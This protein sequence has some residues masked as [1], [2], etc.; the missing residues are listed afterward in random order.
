MAQAR[1]GSNFF[2]LSITVLDQE[3]MDFLF[4]LDNLKRHHVS[5]RGE[6]ARACMSLV[7]GAG[8]GVWE[9]GLVAVWVWVWVGCRC[10]QR[11]G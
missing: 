3:G 10:V 11:G 1:V 9:W 4:G 7:V 2:P 5:E 6:G 8:V